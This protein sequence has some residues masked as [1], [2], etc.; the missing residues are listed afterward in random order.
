MNTIP[1]VKLN[2]GYEM[3]MVGLGVYKASPSETVQAVEWALKGG[4]RHIDTASLYKNE[5]EVGEAIKDSGLARSEIFVTTKIWND[6]IVSERSVEALKESLYRLGMDY[7]DLLLIHW[8]VKGWQK[9]YVDLAECVDKGL[10]RSLGVSN[11]KT[12][13]LEAIKGISKLVPAIDQV[14]THVY[15]QERRIL[16][17]CKSNGITMEAWRPL[18]GAGSREL[19]DPTLVAIAKAHTVSPAQVA[20]KWNVQRGVIVIPKSV[21]QDRIKSNIDLFSFD[22]SGEEMEAISSLDRKDGREGR[23][24]DEYGQ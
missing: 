9:A 19:V 7:V 23:D 18:G 8:P 6:D 10:I 20:L 1:N 24:P 22:L 11:F 5:K 15:F 16:E 12:H 14:E 4:Y 13:H 21:H 17:Y 3:P 2:S